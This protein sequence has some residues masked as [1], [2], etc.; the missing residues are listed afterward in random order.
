MKKLPLLFF[1]LFSSFAAGQVSLV[2]EGEITNNTITG[3]WAGVNIPRS[4]PTKLSFLNNS[5]TSVNSAGYLLQAGDEAPGSTNNNLDGAIIEGNKLTWN[6]T[7]ASSI[8]HGLFTGY[9][10]NYSIK[11]NFLDKTPYGIIFKS[12]NDAGTNMNYSAGYGAAYNIVKNAK[13]SVRMKGINGVQIYNNTFYSNQRSGSVIMIDENHDRVNPAP[14]AGTKIKNN[15]F[16]TVYR[17]QNISVESSCLQ[18][19]ESDY[20]IFY[21]ESGEP[22]F[23]V[24]GVLKSFSQWQA[25]GYDRH[26]VIINPNFINTTDF[27]P[28]ARLNYGVN[29]GSDWQKGLSTTAKW[30]AGSSPSTTVQNGTWQVGAIVYPEVVIPVPV[31]PVYT[32]SV[33]ENTTPALLEMSYDVNLASVVPPITAFSVTV[34]SSTKNINSVAVS[35][36]KVLLTL[37]N[38]VVY[39]DAVTVTYT[40]PSSGML[41]TP[42]GGQASSLS[43]QPVTNKVAY[44]APPTPPPGTTNPPVVTN[45]PPVVVINSPSGISSGFIGE[46]DATGTY[47]VNHDNLSFSW[48]VPSNIPVSSTTS[49]V[50]RFLGPVV[51]SPQSYNFKLNVSDGKSTRSQTVSVEIIPYKPELET[52]DV[53]KI[54]ASEF[55]PPYS[56]YNIIDGNIGTMWSANGDNQWLI[57]DLKESFTIQHVMLAFL[58]EQGWA[59]YFDIYG[60][61]DG[62]IWEPVLIKAS[63]C[64]FSGDLQVFDFP[65]S[66]AAKEFNFIKLVGHTNSSNNWNYISEFKIFG[67]RH[68]N[69]ISFEEQPVKLFPNPAN[70]FVNIRIDDLTMRADFIKIINMSGTV[71]FKDKMDPGTLDYQFLLNLKQGIYIIQIGTGDLTLFTQ[72]LIIAG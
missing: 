34:N 6:G 50:I 44:V 7:D 19:L 69:P 52:A 32:G 29:L 59:S 56:P 28:R 62:E 46:I 68:H 20:N 51:D 15:I 58:P 64:D 57:M 45:S 27:I 49:P 42:S 38:A 25:M 31:T 65:A 10:I 22:V 17:I 48:V 24:D 67:Y 70:D 8:T 4:S 40:K 55:Q 14:S 9:N 23:S 11:Y 37:A 41:Q 21:C 30:V 53:T 16:Y 26:S 39:G 5:I 43:S 66:K 35:G 12:G 54:E 61:E 33:I 36:S 47:D 2:K 3:T 18:Y 1:V 60:S 63:S 71:V 13:L 72:K